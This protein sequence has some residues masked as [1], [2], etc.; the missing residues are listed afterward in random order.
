[1]VKG[2][3][4]VRG[5]EGHRAARRAHCRPDLLAASAD[6]SA[7]SSGTLKSLPLFVPKHLP[8]KRLQFYPAGLS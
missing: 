5:G 4:Q 1:M 8:L 3:T 6:P 2:N 7:R